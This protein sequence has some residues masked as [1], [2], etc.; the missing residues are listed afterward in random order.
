MNRTNLWIIT[1]LSSEL[2]RLKESKEYFSKPT[3]FTRDRVFTFETVFQMLIDLPRLSLSV[4]IEKGLDSINTILGKKTAGTKGGFCKARSKICPELFKVIN[5]K[6]LELFYSKK[7]TADCKR[8]K[9]FIL[10]AIDGAIVDIV[11][12]AEN[13]IE[14]GVQINQHTQVVQGRMMIG[15]DVLNKIV[16]H[17]HLDNLSIGEGNVV[18]QWISGMKKDELNIYDRLFPGMSFQYLHHYYK[19]E[20]VM[21]CKTGHNSRV[22]EFLKSKKKERTEDWA[23]N[24]NAITELKSMGLN[25]NKQTTI[26]VRMVRIE[27]DNG[28]VEVLLTSLLDNKKY[29]HKIFKA[30]YFKRWGVEVE[31]GFLKNTLQIE[32]TSGKKPKTIYQDFYATLFRAN[33][34]AL[35]ELDCEAA[36]EIINKRRIH[37]YA[38]NRTAATGNLKGKLPQLFLLE[39]PQKV[40]EKLITVFVKNLEPV[41][42]D[43]TFKRNKRSQKISGKY[44]PFRNYKRAV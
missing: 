26:R 15:F 36:V 29:P 19:T 21:R 44:K 1:E 3:D 39:N 9:G 2:K 40:Y 23:L 37:N 11:D 6:L 24:N 7:K 22:K 5:E 18:K 17:T 35:I 27:L 31:I 38:I 4:E 28:E 13:R 42:P 32:I 34:Q 10:R 25:V 41:R 8:W 30:L 43:R 33:I 16:T 14:F 12:T 20:Y